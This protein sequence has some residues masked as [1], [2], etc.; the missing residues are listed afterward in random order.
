[1]KAAINLVVLPTCWFMITS[2]DAETAGL[3]ASQAKPAVPL[4]TLHQNRPMPVMAPRAAD[5]AMYLFD[6]KITVDKSVPNGVL[7]DIILFDGFLTAPK[8]GDCEFAVSSNQNCELFL[9]T[10]EDESNFRKLGWTF[11]FRP[12]EDFAYHWGQVVKIP[13]HLKAGHRYRIRAHCRV[14]FR[15]HAPHFTAA[16]RLASEGEFVPIEGEYLSPI[17]K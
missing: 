3:T 9:S 7:Q 14:H 1:M 17:S 5:V 16:W 4:D 13:V 10:D 11:G 6:Y 12:R 15:K 2:C 8:S